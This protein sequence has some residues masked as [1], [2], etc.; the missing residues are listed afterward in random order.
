MISL[1]IDNKNNNNKT[2]LF[3][4]FLAEPLL[5]SAFHILKWGFLTLKWNLVLDYLILKWNFPHNF[6]AISAITAI[7]A[8]LKLISINPKCCFPFQINGNPFQVRGNQGNNAEIRKSSTKFHFKVR[9][10]NF[11]LRKALFKRGVERNSKYKIV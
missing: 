10:P 4:P 6:R 1:Y 9:K 5:K 7:S 11:K 8:V 3:L 2:F